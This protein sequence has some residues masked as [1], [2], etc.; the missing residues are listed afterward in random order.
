M[1][2]ANTQI[3]EQEQRQA[4]YRISMMIEEKGYEFPPFS[5]ER[6][7]CFDAARDFREKHGLAG[8]ARAPK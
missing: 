8:N 4:L 2:D 6:R 3:N 1:N 5:V 7:A